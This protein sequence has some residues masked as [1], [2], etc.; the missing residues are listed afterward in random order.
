MNESFRRLSQASDEGFEKV[1]IYQEMLKDVHSTNRSDYQS[2][3]TSTRDSSRYGE[4]CDELQELLN[5]CYNKN[6]AYL[7]CD[8]S[9]IKISDKYPLLSTLHQ[10]QSEDFLG[11]YGDFLFH[12]VYCQPITGT[13]DTILNWDYVNEILVEMSQYTADGMSLMQAQEHISIQHS[14]NYEHYE[15]KL[16]CISS[17]IDTLVL[18]TITA[19]TTKTPNVDS[20]SINRKE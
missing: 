6:L 12:R 4:Y 11:D 3:I 18:G 19:D 10:N 5:Y 17:T 13:H 9:R 2:A 7:L 15:K 14:I 1:R 20:F 16:E 8:D